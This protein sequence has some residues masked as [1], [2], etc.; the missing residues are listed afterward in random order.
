MA[1]ASRRKAGSPPSESHGNDCRSPLFIPYEPIPST[2]MPPGPREFSALW[3]PCR[4]ARREP[5]GGVTACNDRQSRSRP[6][7]AAP[8]KAAAPAPYRRPRA[9]HSR[10]RRSPS[11]R[12]GLL[13]AL[14]CRIRATPSSRCARPRSST[15]DL[16]PAPAL[17][18]PMDAGAPSAADRFRAHAAARR[19]RRARCCPGRWAGSPSSRGRCRGANDRRSRSRDP[20]LGWR[21]RRFAGRGGKRRMLELFSMLADRGLLPLGAFLLALLLLANEIGYRIGRWRA[22]ARLET[23]ESQHRHAHHRHARPARLHPRPDDLDRRVPLRGAARPGDDRGQCDRHRLAP[24]RAGARRRRPRDPQRAGGVHPV[25]GW[26][27]RAPGTIRWPR[28]R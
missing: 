7:R 2:A 26:T 16:R 1:R 19:R 23:A 15:P 3:P 5:R 21:Q 10:P 25:S 27:I 8:G 11:P 14:R 17:A 20:G 6:D 18:T 12:A 4:G 22:T 28:R 9:G 24:R 13:R